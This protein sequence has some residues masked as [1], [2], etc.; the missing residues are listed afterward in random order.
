MLVVV[1]R[2]DAPHHRL[3]RIKGPHD[4]RENADTFSCLSAK[5]RCCTFTNGLNKIT[6]PLPN[7]RHFEDLRI[8]EYFLSRRAANPSLIVAVQVCDVIMPIARH[9]L[10]TETITI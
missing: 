5:A 10:L 8:E 9:Q 4:R 1:R 2:T 6:E 7:M 3:F